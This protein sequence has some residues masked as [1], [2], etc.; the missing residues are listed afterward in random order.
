MATDRWIRASDQDRDNAAELLSEAYAVGRLGREELDDRATAAYSAKTRG[1]LHDLTADLPL[2]AARTGLPSGAV[3]V[4]RGADGRLT[5][6]MRGIL[7][8]VLA[9]VLAGLV[10]PPAVWVAAVLIPAVLLL[11]ALGISKNAGPAPERDSGRGGG[12]KRGES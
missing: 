1:E 7:L 5:G 2:P 10:I 6:Q 11:P 4:P 8:L 12:A 3:G 9:A